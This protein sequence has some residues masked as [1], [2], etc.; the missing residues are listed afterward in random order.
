MRGAFWELFSFVVLFD[1]MDF[2]IEEEDICDV[3]FIIHDINDNVMFNSTLSIV[4]RALIEV[5]RS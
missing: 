5:C 1:H 3:T 4:Y 2:K